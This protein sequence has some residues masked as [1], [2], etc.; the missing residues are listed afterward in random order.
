M[1][2]P[3][4]E[5][6]Q[7][8]LRLAGS[9]QQRYGTAHMPATVNWDHGPAQCSEWNSP[10]QCTVHLLNE[11]CLSCTA[12]GYAHTSGIPVTPH[13][14]THTFRYGLP[15]LSVLPRLPQLM[16][17]SIEEVKDGGV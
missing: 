14:H 8:W 3:G 17:R 7:L 10:P 6:L 13:P 15:I 16:M 2:P 4:Q 1:F 9:L 5:A 11:T 12:V